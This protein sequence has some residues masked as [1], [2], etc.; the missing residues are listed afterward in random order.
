MLLEVAEELLSAL[1]SDRVGM[2]AVL[3]LQIMHPDKEVRTYDLE[4]HKA[5]NESLVAA[6]SERALARSREEDAV[7]AQVRTVAE[8]RAM[9]RE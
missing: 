5:P 6:R 9:K 4:G 2:S 1:D 3:D 8:K 7:F